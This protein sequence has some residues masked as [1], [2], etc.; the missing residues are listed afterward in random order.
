MEVFSAD[1]TGIDV[2]MRQRHGTQ[3]FKIE[4]KEVAI[5]RVEIRTA[6][7]SN[8]R[9]GF[10]WGEE[11]GREEERVGWKRRTGRRGRQRGGWGG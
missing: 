9:W 1:E 5:Y 2:E 10:V 8:V 7:G 11:G 3:L 4:I 6:A